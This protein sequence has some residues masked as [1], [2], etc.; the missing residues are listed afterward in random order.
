MK[1]GT[2]DIFQ[3]LE[4]HVLDVSLKKCS[5]GLWQDDGIPCSH[6]VAYYKEWE[7]K[8]L[9]LIPQMVPVYYQYKSQRLISQYS[10]KSVVMDKL[11]R[12]G[13]TKLADRVAR[14]SGRPTV[15]RIRSRSVHVIPEH[16]PIK[17]VAYRGTTRR[18]AGSKN[19]E[20]MNCCMIFIRISVF[21]NVVFT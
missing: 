6:A 7:G 18:H 16:L 8:T 10:V 15:K 19:Q 4:I 5:C 17:F 12:D 20:T 11:R 2:G 13:T 14:T 9:N 3:P 21:C 1:K